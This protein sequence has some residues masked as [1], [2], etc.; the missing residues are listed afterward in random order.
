MG[1]L[2]LIVLVQTLG[3]KAFWPHAEVF[4]PKQLPLDDFQGV[5]DPETNSGRESV[6]HG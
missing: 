3:I 2:W 4:C 1:L 6:G 5:G